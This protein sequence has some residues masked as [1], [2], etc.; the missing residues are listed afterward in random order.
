VGEFLN[1]LVGLRKAGVFVIGVIH[2]PEHSGG[3]GR[4][5]IGEVDIR[6]GGIYFVNR[7]VALSM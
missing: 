1:A 4:A 2:V 6:E 3:S 5:N 7:H